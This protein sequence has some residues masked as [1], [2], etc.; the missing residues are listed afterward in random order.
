MPISVS[1]NLIP[2][3]GAKWHVVEDH[4]VKGGLRVVTDAA[5]RDAI[6]LNATAKLT[7]KPGMLLV[8][9]DDGKLW[10]YENAGIWREL[11]KNNI[12]THEQTTPSQE[13]L[14]PHNMNSRFFTYSVFDEAGIQMLP[15]DCVI[16][17]NSNLLLTFLET[18]SG[19]AT[20]TFNV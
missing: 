16:V 9:A 17:D 2:R 3:N 20:L 6:Y 5:A 1:A 10:Q 11:K 18:V 15:N 12:Y 13:W 8:T 4:Y 14:V 7:L 19:T